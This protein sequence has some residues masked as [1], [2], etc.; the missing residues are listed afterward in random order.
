LAKRQSYAFRNLLFPVICMAGILLLLLLADSEIFRSVINLNV[1]LDNGEVL[2][3]KFLD[4]GSL[5]PLLFMAIQVLQILVA[6][7]PGEATG[8][9][10]GYI[11]G[12]WQ[13]FLFSTI[14]LAL[15]S[16]VAFAIGRFLGDLAGDR[17]RRS[18][19]YQ[20]FDG[21]VHKGDYVFPF[22]MF[23]IPGFPKD[24]LSYILGLSRMPMAVFMFI[25]AVG[26]IPG[27]LMLSLQ[28]ASVYQRNYQ[29]LV[30]VTLLGV[31]IFLLSYLF[32]RKF[33]QRFDRQ[34]G[35]MRNEMGDGGL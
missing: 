17:L 25:S 33:L 14:G 23:L 10:G 13:G 21:L 27:T 6:P 26:R 9:L 22:L 24:M 7:I 31:V 8:L 3:R 11:F 20:Q 18:T 2:R 19:A 29:Q 12:L 28:G 30:L 1:V 4:Q 35:E 15:G 5:S 34:A 16:W 32:R